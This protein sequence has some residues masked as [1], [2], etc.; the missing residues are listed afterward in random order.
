MQKHSLLDVPIN[1]ERMLPSPE[2]YI[3]SLEM[4]ECFG[5]RKLGSISSISLASASS[6]SKSMNNNN[7]YEYEDAYNRSLGEDV[8]SN[9]SSSKKRKTSDKTFKPAAKRVECEQPRHSVTPPPPTSNQTTSL[10]I[11]KVEVISVESS[12]EDFDD[13]H[14]LTSDPFLNDA[15]QSASDEAGEESAVVQQLEKV[16]LG[17]HNL[18]KHLMWH[19]VHVTASQLEAHEQV[20]LARSLLD[21]NEAQAQ[22]LSTPEDI[23]DVNPSLPQ[24][25]ASKENPSA[26]SVDRPSA[27]MNRIL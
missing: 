9:K 13:N 24:E 23:D 7:L 12:D 27:N 22:Q 25:L 8:R 11:P 18:P 17:F 6:S 14:L 10:I 3:D 21:K 16:L 20:R 26:F 19:F 15:S 4:D 1:D 5:E 2:V